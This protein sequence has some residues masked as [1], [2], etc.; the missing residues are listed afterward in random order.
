MSQVFILNWEFKIKFHILFASNL[1]ASM[2][3]Y[4]YYTAYIFTSWKKQ[5]REIGHVTLMCGLI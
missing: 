2:D 3:L 1:T 4:I 5:R